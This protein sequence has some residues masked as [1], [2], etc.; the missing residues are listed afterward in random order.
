MKLD[1][2]IIYSSHKAADQMFQAMLLVKNKV[3]FQDLNYIDE[4]TAE[5]NLEIAQARQ[6]MLA[7]S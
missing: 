2:Y 1:S 5:A 7:E 6:A 4:E 3:A